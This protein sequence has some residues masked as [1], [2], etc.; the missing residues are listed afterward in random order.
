MVDLFRWP[1]FP[2]RAQ[3]VAY[4]IAL[5]ACAVPGGTPVAADPLEGGA[6]SLTLGSPLERGTLVKAVLERNPTLGAARHAWQASLQRVSRE[7]SF[8]DP[9]VSYSFGPLSIGAD[10]ARYGQVVRLT[11]HLPASG[12]LRLRGEVAR[13]EAEVAR[14][15]YR[16]ARLGLAHMAALLFDDYYYVNRAIEINEEH[17]LLLEDFKRIATARYAAGT[18]TQQDPLQAEVEV[19]HLHHRR[20]VLAAR[21]TDTA[22]QVYVE[23]N[24]MGISDEDRE[25]I[26]EKFVRGKSSDGR[27]V[28]AGLGLPLVRSLV[29]LHGGELSLDSEPHQGTR[30]TCTFPVAPEAGRVDSAEAAPEPRRA[31][32]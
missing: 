20:I 18:A 31:K 16:A 29:E 28:G 21:R 1:P 2:R 23:D 30:I 27:A 24:G 11:Q 32:A 25:R 13:A 17:V 26:F 4:I 19:A 22:L 14:H 10:D 9:T 12:T 5:L 7:D 3:A 6:D 8:D 15:G